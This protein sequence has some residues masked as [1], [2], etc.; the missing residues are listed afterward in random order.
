MVAEHIYTLALYCCVVINRHALIKF[1][2]EAIDVHSN[3]KSSNEI[4]RMFPI[5]RHAHSLKY[6]TLRP[7]T[8][9]QKTKS[10]IFEKF[11]AQQK[12][13]LCLPRLWYTATFQ[14]LDDPSWQK[15]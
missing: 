10:L 3:T 6:R 1:W 5:S 12:E 11:S 8:K 2:Y 13:W 15:V 7:E 4:V 14:K 9:N